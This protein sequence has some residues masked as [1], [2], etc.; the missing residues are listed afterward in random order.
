V[1]SGGVRYGVWQSAFTFIY[2]LS[3][4]FESPSVT[5]GGGSGARKNASVM[6]LFPKQNPLTRFRRHVIAKYYIVDRLAGRHWGKR[7]STI[8]VHSVR[9]S[10]TFSPSGGCSTYTQLIPQERK[11]ERERPPL[12]AHKVKGKKFAPFPFCFIQGRWTQTSL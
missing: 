9:A 12:T 11:P 1:N 5:G 7:A 6:S 8:V 4:R 10:S 2:P 3:L